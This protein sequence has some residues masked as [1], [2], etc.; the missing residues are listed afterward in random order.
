M[1]I[2]DF[3]PNSTGLSPAETKRYTG[4][5]QIVNVLTRDTGILD[6]CLTNKPNLFNSPKQLP[7][8]GSSDHDTVSITPQLSNTCAKNTN[9]TV[10]KRDLRPS[11]IR[12]F[13]RW[14]TQQDWQ[15]VFN[16][17][18]VKDKFEAFTSILS[19][20]VDT[21]LPFR[22]IRRCSSDKPWITTKLKSLVAKRQS[23]LHVNGRTR[24]YISSTE[25][26]YK[27]NAPEP[28]SLIT[29]TELQPSRQPMLN[30][31]GKKQK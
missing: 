4:L 3:N 25:M 16:E 11:R 14:I 22:K 30:V 18:L 10:F 27:G 9:Y 26:Q 29:T 19:Y 6:W 23:V 24:N 28:K 15:N 13:G 8:L 31:G 12:D 5:T 20:G 7:K 21:Y 17:P 2:G 1:I